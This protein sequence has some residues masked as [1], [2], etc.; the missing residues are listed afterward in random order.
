[1]RL[2][3]RVRLDQFDPVAERIG[4]NESRMRLARRNEILFDAEMNFQIA[5]L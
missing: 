1:M 2:L 4:D 5:A 3:F